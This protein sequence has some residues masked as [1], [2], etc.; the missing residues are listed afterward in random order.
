M[1]KVQTKLVTQNYRKKRHVLTFVLTW[2]HTNTC[3]I[4]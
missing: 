1:T 4:D 3:L 2:W